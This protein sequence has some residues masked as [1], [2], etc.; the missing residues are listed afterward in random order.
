[1]SVAN[2]SKHEAY[3]NACALPVCSLLTFMSFSDSVRS[4]WQQDFWPWYKTQILSLLPRRWH[5]QRER[6]HFL[7]LIPLNDAATLT[8]LPED[9]PLG[10][11]VDVIRWVDGR[12]FDEGMVEINEQGAARLTDLARAG[13]LALPLAIGIAPQDLLETEIRLPLAAERSLAS[14]M[15]FEI[16]RVTPFMTRSL[17]WSAVITKRI[18]THQ[19]LL[20]RLRCTPR[21][22][23][24]GLVSWLARHRFG[25]VEI[26][27]ATSATAPSGWRSIPIGQAADRTRNLRLLWLCVVL[28]VAAALGAGLRQNAQSRALETQIDALQPAVTHA[29]MLRSRYETLTGNP[30]ILARQSEASGSVSKAMETLS[31]ALPDQAYLTEFALHARQMELT[32]RAPSAAALLERMARDHHFQDPSLSGAVTRS[33]DEK[34]DVFTIRTRFA[35]ESSQPPHAEPGR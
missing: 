32:G 21:A 28:V 15:T 26:V 19:R 5:R 7:L 31:A 33:D 9:E 3:L 35:D 11:T 6:S 27:A 25:P 18:A 23:I 13:R 30:A 14:V 24:A 17:F 12:A 10:T 34:D 8:D 16:P 22:P 2:R 4:F 29:Q 1:M 20:V